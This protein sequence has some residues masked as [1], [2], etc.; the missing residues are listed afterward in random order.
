MEGPGTLPAV[1]AVIIIL[2]IGVLCVAVLLRYVRFRRIAEVLPDPRAI[3]RAEPMTL[4][5]KRDLIASG[6][7]D[8][9]A[10]LPAGELEVT[11]QALWNAMLLETVSDGSIDPREMRFVADLFSRITGDP[12]DHQAVGE[13]AK[14]AR[15][16]RRS[17]L[18]EI[19]KARTAGGAAKEY[20]LAGAFLV[21]VSD[22]ALADSETDCLG[23]I[24]DALGIGRRDS[25]AILSGIAKRL[26][27]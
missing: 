1:V 16:D 21:T 20:V 8:I 27:V 9:A 15:G 23:E 14:A 25:E 11:R 24:A 18:A 17:A 3:A 5:E 12:V 10:K 2:A 7:L 13:A 19:A 22:Y 26:G 6:L 4:D